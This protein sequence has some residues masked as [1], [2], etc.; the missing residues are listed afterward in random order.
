MD[1]HILRAEDF[2]LA[3]Q[4]FQGLYSI[5]EF[6][7]TSTHSQAKVFW[8]SSGHG[9]KIFALFCLRKDVAE[10]KREQF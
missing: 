4:G 1:V 6:G 7:C 9:W 5:I 3:S 10:E 2:L 8:F